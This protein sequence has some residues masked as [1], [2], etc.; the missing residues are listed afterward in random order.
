MFSGIAA[1]GEEVGKLVEV[2]DTALF[3]D[4]RGGDEGVDPFDEPLR[5]EN[6]DGLEQGVVGKVENDANLME[7]AE[8]SL[9]HFG[10]VNVV[11]GA[12]GLVVGVGDDVGLFLPLA[13]PLF[14][15]RP[16]GWLWILEVGKGLDGGCQDPNL[17]TRLK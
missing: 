13:Q 2:E 12:D 6:A 10:I 3:A 11:V 7:I 17:S 8:Q 4:G 16:A 9:L 1:G 14:D 5:V 15:A